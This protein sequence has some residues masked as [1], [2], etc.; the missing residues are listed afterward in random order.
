[1]KGDPGVLLRYVLLEQLWSAAAVGV[2]AAKRSGSDHVPLGTA[3]GDTKASVTPA[4]CKRGHQPH[5][6]GGVRG[7]IN[8]S[9]IRPK[10]GTKTKSPD[11]HLRIAP[12]TEQVK[13]PITKHDRGFFGWVCFQKR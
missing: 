13:Y 1:M 6:L 7:L 3:L 9:T 2:P 11:I 10:A 4:V 5:I 12:S 8:A